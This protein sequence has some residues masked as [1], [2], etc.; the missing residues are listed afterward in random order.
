MKNDV[1]TKAKELKEKYDSLQTY[2]NKLYNAK[3]NSLSKITLD[4]TV[5]PHN[6]RGELYFKNRSL[7]QEAI[8][9][10]IELVTVEIEELQKQFDEL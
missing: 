9:K 1:F 10:E 4:Y 8:E 5:G 3:G 2:R 7:M 6:R